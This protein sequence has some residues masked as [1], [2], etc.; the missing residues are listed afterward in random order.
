MHYFFDQTQNKAI[1]TFFFV[2]KV[3]ASVILLVVSCIY[4]MVSLRRLKQTTL[5]VQQTNE[6]VV[7]DAMIFKVKYRV[8]LCKLCYSILL[9]YYS[10]QIVSWSSLMLYHY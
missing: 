3:A 5:I 10:F 8:K 1:E 6:E 4:F 9:I 2:Y 7:Q